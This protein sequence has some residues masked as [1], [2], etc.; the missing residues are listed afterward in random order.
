MLDF[1]FDDHRNEITINVVSFN[2][3]PVIVIEINIECSSLFLLHFGFATGSKE[4]SAV[5][6]LNF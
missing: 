3:S 2:H 6:P 1:N 4:R 5:L